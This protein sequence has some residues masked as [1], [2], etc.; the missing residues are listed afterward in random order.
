MRLMNEVLKEFV[1]K[2]VIV[3]LDGVVIFNQ[4]KEGHLR[5]VSYVLERLQ[6]EKLLINLKKCTFM[7]SELVYLGLS[8]QRMG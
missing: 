4:T 6:Q 3:Y 8:V 2:F 1:G 5:H 7:R